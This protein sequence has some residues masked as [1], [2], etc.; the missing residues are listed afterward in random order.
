[1]IVIPDCQLVT[2]ERKALG[3]AQRGQV[4]IFLIGNAIIGTGALR[5]R[6]LT[7]AQLGL[8]YTVRTRIRA[9]TS[10]AMHLADPIKFQCNRAVAQHGPGSCRGPQGHQ[11]PT[12]I[13][14][15]INCN[16]RQWRG[17][18]RL[19]REN[20]QCHCTTRQ[21]EQNAERQ[22]VMVEDPMINSLLIHCCN[23]SPCAVHS[24]GVPYR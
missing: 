10:T 5:A 19:H 9:A 3:T 16:R 23:F 4:L 15:R 18:G 11:L 6:E 14:Q 2:I 20:R 17:R 7:N 13:G 1:M 8:F 21:Q 12:A 24:G 22:Q